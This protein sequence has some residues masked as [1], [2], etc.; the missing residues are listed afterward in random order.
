MGP[1]EISVLGTGVGDCSEPPWCCCGYFGLHWPC[2]GVVGCTWSPHFFTPALHPPEVGEMCLETTKSFCILCASPVFLH[3]ICAVLQPE[4][5]TKS[6]QHFEGHS[7]L[8]SSNFFSGTEW[9]RAGARK[10]AESLKC[11]CQTSEGAQTSLT[12]GAG[13]FPALAQAGRVCLT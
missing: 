2:A 3:S 5:L 1:N 13:L 8:G 7:C 6:W 11:C 12:H 4:R 9:F 10:P